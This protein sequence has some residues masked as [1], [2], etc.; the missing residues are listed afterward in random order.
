MR[1]DWTKAPDWA[2]WYAEDADGTP[3]WYDSTPMLDLVQDL[4][5]SMG[6]RSDFAHEAAEPHETPWPHTLRQ[7][8]A[9]DTTGPSPA[10]REALVELSGR[11]LVALAGSGDAATPEGAASWAVD[12][13]RA[14]LRECGA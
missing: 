9:P 13:A 2:Q 1:V 4:F 7:R 5:C 6:A 12:A 10:D 8:P 11:V 3:W 14:L